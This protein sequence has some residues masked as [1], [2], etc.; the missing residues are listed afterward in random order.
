M[1]ELQSRHMQT[2]PLYSNSLVYIN[3]GRRLIPRLA[4]C[5]ILSCAM[6]MGRMV[7]DD[8]RLSHVFLLSKWPRVVI[9]DRMACRSSLALRLQMTESSGPGIGN[10]SLF[11]PSLKM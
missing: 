2:S 4:I 7:F 9:E 3:Q 1:I 5:D 8:H 10:S 11:S 6:G